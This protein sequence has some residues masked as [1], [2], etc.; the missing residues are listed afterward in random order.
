[1]KA[2]Q[3]LFS[4]SVLSNTDKTIPSSHLSLPLFSVQTDD[5]LTQTD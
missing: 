2:L 5:N 3:I 1:M 4:F